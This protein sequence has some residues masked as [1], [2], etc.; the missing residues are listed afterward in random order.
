MILKT[1]LS[2]LQMLPHGQLA[3]ENAV[4]SDEMITQI[5][6]AHV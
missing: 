4:T 5:G 6:R 2:S 3:L 1:L